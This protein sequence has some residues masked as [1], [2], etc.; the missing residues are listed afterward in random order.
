MCRG[1]PTRPPII[2]A[3]RFGI[4]LSIPVLYCS[5]VVSRSFHGFPVKMFRNLI[6]LGVVAVGMLTSTLAATNG[7]VNANQQQPPAVG[8]A[9]KKI[10]IPTDHSS[11]KAPTMEERKTIHETT[12]K[13]AKKVNKKKFETK[14]PKRD[15]SNQEFKRDVKAAEIRVESM[16]STP[17]SKVANK[18]MAQMRTYYGSSCDESY[19]IEANGILTNA[20]LEDRT[21]HSYTNSWGYSYDYDTYAT[22]VSAIKTTVN[23]VSYGTAV[24][25]YF[26]Y[27]DCYSPDSSST[28]V[29]DSYALDT[30]YSYFNY[31]DW[32]YYSHKVS[33]SNDMPSQTSGV[34]FKEYQGLRACRAQDQNGIKSYNFF[35]SGHCYI[36]DEGNQSFMYYCSSDGTPRMGFYSD[37]SCNTYNY[38]FNLD[39]WNCYGSDDKYDYHC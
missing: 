39:D 22:S 14:V 19:L 21:S 28:E 37:L 13:L 8:K 35:A 36:N 17:S 38:S 16:G 33:F 6:V 20:C 29:S 25:T 32:M 10:P 18:V 3:G 9:H 26:N 2:A 4:L 11:V 23:G 24:Q 34:F 7:F 12:V 15:F 30:C 27:A 1:A 5:I 31:D